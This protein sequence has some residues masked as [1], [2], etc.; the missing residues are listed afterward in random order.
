MLFHSKHGG[1]QMGAPVARV[2]SGLSDAEFADISD[3]LRNFWVETREPGVRVPTCYRVVKNAP[4]VW[5]DVWITDP[6]KSIVVKVNPAP[7]SRIPFVTAPLSLLGYPC[8]ACAAHS[9]R[10]AALALANMHMPLQ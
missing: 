6:M 7:T 1:V 9:C 2:G 3:R 8:A 4:K 5:P 10:S